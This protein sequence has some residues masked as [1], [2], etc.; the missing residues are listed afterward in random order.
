MITVEY[1]ISALRFGIFPNNS[2]LYN[3]QSP[4]LIEA[5]NA[6]FAIF[7]KYVQDDCQH[8][9][10][11]VSALY[12]AYTEVELVKMLGN[13]K[14]PLGAIYADSGGLQVVTAGKSINEQLKQEIYKTQ[15]FSDYAMCFDSIS[16]IR[17]ALP[18]EKRTRN[19]RS[20]ISNKIFVDSGHL[21]AAQITANNIKEQVEAFKK[22]NAKTKVIIIVQGNTID[23]MLQFYNEIE[24]KLEQ[25]DYEYIGGLAVADTCIGSGPLESIKMLQAARAISDNCHPNV[26]QHL[27]VLGVGSLDRM[28]PIMYLAKSKYLDKFKR[29]S[30][31]SSSH[32]STF[33]YG[34]LKLNGGC[35]P[36]GSTKTARSFAHF[37][38]LYDYFHDY[39]KIM[40][41]D[42]FLNIV[43]GEG[44]H[45]DTNSK[46]YYSNLKKRLFAS[47]SQYLTIGL[48]MKAMHTLYQVH[49]FVVNVDKMMIDKKI[50][51]R[52]I[53]QK[54]QAQAI[55]L[56]RKVSNHEHMNWWMKN[57]GAENVTSKSITNSKEMT[58]KLPFKSVTV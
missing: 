10:T 42:E 46:W 27:H 9:D 21:E 1:V 26:S 39:L 43:F 22:L 38:N 52:N 17:Q 16:L 49:N 25:D 7:T 36:L 3:N 50:A 53:R 32:T 20:N 56:L 30:Y 19:E 44:T 40:S 14:L 18:G 6:L 2:K 12:N 41:K 13:Y 8:T 47:K 34:L 45:N 28:R 29:I 11:K 35:T 37:S 5:L 54:K 31:D 33:D 48:L 23:D 57:G 4:E 15:T 58:K 55:L 24:K 51:H